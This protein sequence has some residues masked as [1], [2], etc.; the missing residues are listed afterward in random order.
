M[1]EIIE[2]FLA[3]VDSVEYG[4]VTVVVT[5][6]QGEIVSIEKQIMEKEKRKLD[7]K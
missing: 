7:K 2:W 5:K 3:A 1:R 6:H 4:T